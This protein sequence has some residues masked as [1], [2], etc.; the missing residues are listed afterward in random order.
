MYVSNEN[1]R[2][3]TWENSIFEVPNK[4]GTLYVQ[5]LHD[6]SWFMGGHMIFLELK[7][8]IEFPKKN[9]SQRKN[10]ILKKNVSTLI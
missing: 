1:S 8:K 9:F 6:F 2:L 4:L 10:R 7:N 3:Q 5:I